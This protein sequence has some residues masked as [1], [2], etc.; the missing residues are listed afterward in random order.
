MDRGHGG[1]DA[2]LVTGQGQE[3][4]GEQERGPLP[5]MGA[6]VVTEVHWQVPLEIFNDSTP[7]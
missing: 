6:A 1:K 7:C 3:V 2:T 5:S 4:W